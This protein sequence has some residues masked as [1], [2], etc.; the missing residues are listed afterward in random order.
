MLGS[1]PTANILAH[2]HPRPHGPCQENNMNN[3][4]CFESADVCCQQKK[5]KN[6][7]N[8]PNCCPPKII[9]FV[10]DPG[11]R[12]ASSR[13]SKRCKPCMECNCKLIP[14]KCG[15]PPTI[16]CKCKTTGQ[17]DPCEREEYCCTLKCK[18]K[19]K[20]SSKKLYELFSNKKSKSKS[21]SICVDFCQDED[22]VCSDSC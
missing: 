9:G 5:K 11:C 21:R 4:I 7:Q 20:N 8:C 13:K 1:M 3:I 17:N 10:V 6:K 15:K 2:F 19:K 16:C 14:S 18:K 22:N 12:E